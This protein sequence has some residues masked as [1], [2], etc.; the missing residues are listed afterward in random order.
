MARIVQYLETGRLDY[1]KALRLQQFFAKKPAESFRNVLILTEH[2][3]VYTVGIRSGACGA[4]EADKLQQ[5]GAEFYRTN[6]GGL[7]T[8]HGPGQLIAYPILNLRHFQP[9]VR[10]YVGKIEETVVDLCRKFEIRAGQTADMGVWVNDKKICAL[11]L[12]VSRLITS[13]GLA[14]N[15][16]TDLSWFRHIVPCGLVGRGV[17]SVSEQ[18]GRNVEIGEVIPPFLD[19]FKV[20]FDCELEKFPDA[21]RF[22]LFNYINGD[23][24]PKDAAKMTRK[25]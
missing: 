7:I 24:E 9:S 14:L 21:G 20:T 3:P 13:H 6:R 11:G 8:F 17:T 10:W 2:D 4:Q 25:Q 5:L 16:N 12:H 15:C 1:Q 18:V 19:S 22:D 23:E